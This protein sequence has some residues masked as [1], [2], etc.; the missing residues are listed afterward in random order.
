MTEHILTL[1]IIGVTHKNS[2]ISWY[3]WFIYFFFQKFQQLSN[4]SHM[5]LHPFNMSDQKKLTPLVTPFCFSCLVK[6]ILWKRES[7]ALH[8]QKKTHFSHFFFTLTHI[9][10]RWFSKVILICTFLEYKSIII[11]IKGVHM[12]DFVAQ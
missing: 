7:S 11:T 12:L 2:N 5:H 4:N 3:H 9:F 1:L 6:H 8:T 10:L